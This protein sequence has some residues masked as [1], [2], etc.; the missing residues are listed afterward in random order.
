MKKMDEM[1]IS[2]NFKAIKWSYLFTVIALF[3][4]TLNDLIR[5]HTIS[6]ACFILITQYLIYL[7]F[8]QIYKWKMGDADG[9]KG[10]ILSIIGFVVFLVIFGVLLLYFPQ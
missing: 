4:W 1:Q 6:L 5:L 7:F 9:R 2:I 10:L 8:Y 3:L